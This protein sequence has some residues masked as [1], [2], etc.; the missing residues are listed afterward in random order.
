M[1]SDSALNS[2]RLWSKFEDEKLVSLVQRFGDQT[3]KEGNWSEIS[4]YL[5]GRSNKV[6]RVDVLG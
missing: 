3:G 2:R 5:P 4:R 1:A 6:G